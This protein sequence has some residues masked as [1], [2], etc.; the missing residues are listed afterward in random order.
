MNNF[1]YK[2]EIVVLNI[3]LN[4]S[5]NITYSI[6]EHIID[7]IV[8]VIE[9][10]RIDLE[11][12]YNIGFLYIIFKSFIFLPRELKGVFKLW[13]VFVYYRFIAYR[14]ISFLLLFKVFDHTLLLCKFVFK[15]IVFLLKVIKVITDQFKSV[16]LLLDYC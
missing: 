13:S 1:F 3:V 4:I 9:G 14:R 12:S 7:L 6:R 11:F 2:V 5:L 15:V 10:S 16:L 8:F